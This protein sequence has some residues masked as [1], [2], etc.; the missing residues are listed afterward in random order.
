MFVSPQKVLFLGHWSCNAGNHNLALPAP[1]SS[2]LPSS[3]S[4]SRTRARA[5]SHEVRGST[6][7]PQLP[8]R[9]RIFPPERRFHTSGR[10]EGKQRV[11]WAGRRRAV[12]QSGERARWC[13]AS[14]AKRSAPVPPSLDV[15]GTTLVDPSPPGPL[16]PGLR[17]VDPRAGRGRTES[18]AKRETRGGTWS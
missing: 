17:A 7:M 9:T 12:L 10:L 1:S 15:T 6:S 5:S 4:R 11:S 8:E 3:E 18:T 2:P 16:G 13:G 14:G